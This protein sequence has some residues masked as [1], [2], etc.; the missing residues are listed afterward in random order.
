MMRFRLTLEF[1]GLAF[2]LAAHF[3]LA[4][5]YGLGSSLRGVL[6]TVYWPAIGLGYLCILGLA[7]ARP[8]RLAAVPLRQAFDTLLVTAPLALALTVAFVWAR[9]PLAFPSW[10]GHGL[11]ATGGEANAALFPWIH[12]I[13]WASALAYVATP[14]PRHDRPA[15]S[16][17]P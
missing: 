16:A 2:Y 10:D 5:L 15:V 17:K 11:G 14:G 4:F 1:L 9:W 12:T 8:A 6:P 13:L 3:P 7:L